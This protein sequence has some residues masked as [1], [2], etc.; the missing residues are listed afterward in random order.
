MEQLQA[1]DAVF[2]FY[3]GYKIGGQNI[4]NQGTH[5]IADALDAVLSFTSGG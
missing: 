3:Q 2:I 5:F 1:T 4:M